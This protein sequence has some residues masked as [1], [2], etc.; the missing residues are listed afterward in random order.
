MTALT[1]IKPLG[2]EVILFPDRGSCGYSAKRLE[3]KEV[4]ILAGKTK[5]QDTSSLSYL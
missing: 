2:K 1:V 5:Q 3:R 4:C